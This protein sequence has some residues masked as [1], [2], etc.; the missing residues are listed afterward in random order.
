MS[1]LFTL[2]KA[3]ASAADAFGNGAEHFDDRLA[4]G[5]RGLSLLH[6]DVTVLVKGSRLNRLEQ[7]VEL[8]AGSSKGA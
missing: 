6:R 2:G 7:V 3:A 4:M 1:R 5:Q 8:L